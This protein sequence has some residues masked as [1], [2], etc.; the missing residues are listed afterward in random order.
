VEVAE[1][2]EVAEVFYNK[3]E[4]EMA[5]DFQN[6]VKTWND[7]DAAGIPLETL[8]DRIGF[9]VRKRSATGLTLKPGRDRL[10]SCLTELKNSQFAY[11]LPVFVRCDGPGKTI[12][13]DAWIG[14]PW[15]DTNIQ[16]LED[17]REGKRPGYY[18]FP[19][20]T[21]RFP[22][23]NVLNHR[24]NSVLSRGDI[25]DG[26]LLAVGSAPPDEYKHRDKVEITLTLV[27][28]WECEQKLPMQM[29]V[30]RRAHRRTAIHS[31]RERN[32]LL[33]R[34]D[35]IGPPRSLIA[36]PVPISREAEEKMY[37]SFLAEYENK[38]T[39]RG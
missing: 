38:V 14:T 26:L 20:D 32:P 18:E 22:R 12:I 34:R 1:V 28:Q 31:I 13:C 29:T 33:S 19:G 15:S 30:Y 23:E 24:I 3:K 21:E 27:D 5:S 37:R 9:D 8:K 35:V 25:R 16:W 2:A 6:M 39:H 36:P 4:R 11:V 7:L 10:R 17:P